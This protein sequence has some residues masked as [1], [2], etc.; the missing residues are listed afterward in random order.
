M[1]TYGLFRCIP[2]VDRGEVIVQ[3][4]CPIHATDKLE[5]LEDR[6]HAIEHR[7]IVQGTELALLLKHEVEGNGLEI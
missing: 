4:I 6:I 7:L 5:D 1:I 2:E 3:Q